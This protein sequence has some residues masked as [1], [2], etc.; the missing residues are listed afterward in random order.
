MALT[1]DPVNPLSQ[2]LYAL[3]APETKR[4]W[5]NRLKIVINRTFFAVLIMHNNEQDRIIAS[6]VHRLDLVT[7]GLEILLF[8]IPLLMQIYF[9]NMSS[10]HYLLW[11]AMTVDRP[12]N[13]NTFQYTDHR[14]SSSDPSLPPAFFDL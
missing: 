1:E 13:L 6:Y 3:K 5:P 4:Q 7:V 10:Q 2:F 9:Q 12:R 8:I 11:H 14:F